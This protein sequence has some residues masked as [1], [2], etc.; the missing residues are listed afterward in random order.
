MGRRE[1]GDAKH[2]VFDRSEDGQGGAGCRPLQVA[3]ATGHLRSARVARAGQPTR[4]AL[5]SHS[6]SRNDFFCT[7]P[8]EVFGIS[9]NSTAAGRM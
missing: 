3:N 5:P 1:S 9:A 6:L 2:H 8:V 4:R 7:L